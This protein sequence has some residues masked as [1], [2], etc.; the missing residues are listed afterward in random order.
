[1]KFKQIV[2]GVASTTLA[3][4]AYSQQQ[5]NI[6]FVLAD[7]W[8]F[9]HAGV[10][11]DA[12]AHTP[13]FDKVAREGA[14]FMDVHCT[15]PSGAPSRAALL[16]GQYPHQNGEAANLWSRF[17]DNPI[18][19]DIL[20]KDGYYVGSEKK[21]W[22]PGNFKASGFQQNPAG[23]QYKSFQEFLEENSAGKPFCFWHGSRYPHRPYEVGI[24]QK[25]GYDPGKLTVPAFMPDTRKVREDLAD[26]YYYV[27]QFDKDLG[28]MLKLL[29]EKGML[30]NTLVVV[31]SDNG[32]PFPKA[33]A[34][35][36]DYG[37]R[38][39]MA[40]MWKG[41][42]KPGTVITDATSHIDVAPTFIAAAGATQ[43]QVMQG[44]DLIPLIQ[45]K[46]GRNNPLV[47]TE[48][49]RHAYVREG[50]LSYPSRAIRDK[51][52][53]YIINLR[54]DRYPAGD[55]VRA[56][57]VGVYGDVDAG[58]AKQEMI[59]NKEKYAEL[60]QQAFGLR[61]AEELYDLS[62]DPFQQKNLASDPD[63]YMAKRIMGQK[64]RNFMY[65]TDDSRAT[66]DDDRYDKYPYY[67]L[68][69]NYKPSPIQK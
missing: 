61:P 37:T 67:G 44:K 13:N 19:T 57:D 47:F 3:I 55:P 5:P 21:G 56:Y 18:Y 31:T 23:K 39:P 15:A 64:L 63:Y 29:E 60:F 38:M 12:N 65:E 58:L 26:Y 6:L 2:L 40:I 10:Y 27:E 33:K 66:V 43:P 11:G 35:L 9:P 20:E 54:P 46:E 51:D 34:T 22:G 1:M 32:M 36:Y 45:G 42:I 53:L 7:D 4:N 52:Y 14:L 69:S 25:N 24:G 8:S 30:D 50:N 48:R 41:K 28:K 59:D 49:E 68:P 62:K 16:T 17:T